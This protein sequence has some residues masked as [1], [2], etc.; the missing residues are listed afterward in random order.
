MARIKHGPAA[1]ELGVDTGSKAARVTVYGSDGREKADPTTA[2]FTASSGNLTI[3]AAAHAATAGFFWLINP[4]GNPKNV[5]LRRVEFE[6]APTAATVFVTSPRVTVERM[7]FTGTAS[8]AQITPSKVK[9]SMANPTGLLLTANTG[10]T[11][12]AGAVAYTFLVTAILTAVG[13]SNP[14]MLEWEPPEEGMKDLASGEGIVIRQADAGSASD[15]RKAVVNLA[16]EEYT[17]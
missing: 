11:I 4:I 16:W 6:S 7:T 15:T 2:K 1:D 12:I 9:S 5:K 3:L 10:L 14:S 17:E 8:G 13:V